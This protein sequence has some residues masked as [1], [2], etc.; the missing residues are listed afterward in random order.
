[1]ALLDVRS[2]DD[3]GLY[4]KRTHRDAERDEA[5][6][7][8]DFLAL[9]GIG[10]GVLPQP[11]QRLGATDVAE[12]RRKFA[13]LVGVDSYLGGGDTF[14]MYFAELAHTE[15]VLSRSSCALVVR[16]ELTELAAEQAQQTGWAAFDSGFRG[17]AVD[18]FEYSRRAAEEAEN[19]E[20]VANAFVHIAYTSGTRESVRAA[21]SA[22]AAVG[23][24]ASPK[25]RA[26][27]ESRR[28]WSLAASGDC[29]GAARSLDAAR[30]ALEEKAGTD[31]PWCAWVDHAELDIMTGRVWAVLHRPDR[32]IKP[33][34]SAL[35][36]YPDHWARD[37][38]LYLT[39]LADAYLEAGDEGA[40]VSATERALTLAG[41]VASARPSI[42]IREV[43]ERC[44]TAGVPG[45]A[46]LA[47]RAASAQVPIPAR[48]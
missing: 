27:L 37:K 17:K 8:R 24:G 22:C 19:R 5:T 30:D 48:L 40:A 16:R 43:A 28:A 33:L 13:R 23:D 45:A 7:R 2:P 12:M 11:P 18:L 20:L 9:A 47:M 46:E 6:K 25:A 15:Q 39:W 29:D 34:E 44:A 35:A 26:L 10:V 32:A 21:D 41:R 4:P 36:A 3:L 42:R 31:A 14:R 38:A 1:M